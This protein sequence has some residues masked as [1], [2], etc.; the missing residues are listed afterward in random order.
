MSVQNVYFGEDVE[1]LA[2]QY[3]LEKRP[4]SVGAK[5][6]THVPGTVPPGPSY[7]WRV[8]LSRDSVSSSTGG[9]PTWL[10]PRFVLAVMRQ[11]L[12]MRPY[13][14]QCH[15]VKNATKNRYKDIS[16]YDSTRVVLTSCPSDDYINANH[17][18]ME[19]PGSGIINR[20]ID[21]QG[22]LSTTCLDFW[23]MIWEQE[24]SLVIMLTTVVERARIKCLKFWSDKDETVLYG[25]VSV[26]C[27]REEQ[28]RL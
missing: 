17:V 12:T 5:Q 10:Y 6:A 16:S 25:S 28:F 20:N 27:T 11:F 15:L 13:N 22:P 23:Y 24:S 7:C 8:G 1:E 2:F 21:T 19:I 4:S 14:L 3:V 18:V 26:T 9:T